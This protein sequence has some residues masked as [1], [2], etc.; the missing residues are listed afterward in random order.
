MRGSLLTLG[1]ISDLNCQS[2]FRS[3]EATLRH[4]KPYL[5]VDSAMLVM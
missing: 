3:L 5:V 4:K 1:C 2:S